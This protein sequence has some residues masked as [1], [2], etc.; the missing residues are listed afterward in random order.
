MDVRELAA[1]LP[2]ETPQVVA[3]RQRT[4]EL[5]GAVTGDLAESGRSTPLRGLAARNAELRTLAPRAR[6]HVLVMQTFYTFDPEDPGLDLSRWLASRGVRLQL[7]TRPT[8]TRTHPLLAS[9]YPTTLLGPV[10]AR[11]LVVDDQVALLAGPD[12]A[13]GEPV[14]WRTADGD[15][16]AGLR[17]LWKETVPLCR[18]ILEPGA[19]PPLTERQLG[20]ARLLCTGEKDRAIAH[21]LGL[22][23]RTVE[24]E[25][26]VVLQALGAGSRTEAVLL[27]RGRGV[28]GGGRA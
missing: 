4:I 6:E 3:L 5:V 12:D 15:V 26:R 7:A 17:E 9:I 20:V 2:G 14:T 18:P 23:E 13:E 8:T 16:V 22:S 10:F 25:V 24:R 11:C 1:R 28:N 19:A 27:M 21:A